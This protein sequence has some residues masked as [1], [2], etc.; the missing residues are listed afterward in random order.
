MAE[1]LL[2]EDKKRGGL[3]S[4]ALTFVGTDG[5]MTKTTTMNAIKKYNGLGTVLD[6]STFK[7]IVSGRGD[8]S[9]SA[10]STENEVCLPKIQCIVATKSAQAG[11]NGLWLKYGKKKGIHVSPYEL[12]QEFG[13]VHRRMNAAPGSNSYEIHLDFNSYISI[14]LR[15]MQCDNAAEQKKQ[16]PA[17]YIVMGCKLVPTDCYY[18]STENYFEYDPISNK[19]PCVHFCSYC[20]GDVP[21]FTKQVN[22]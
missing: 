16:L 15:T 11:I 6:L 18:T 19:K 3:D 21:N 12:V 13:W 22:K 20:L 9:T 10:N 17:H 7:S 2:E 14:F 1:N 5:I 4:V 8:I